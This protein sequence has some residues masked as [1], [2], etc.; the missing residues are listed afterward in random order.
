MTAPNAAATAGAIDPVAVALANAPEDER[1]VTEDEVAARRAA[2]ADP[3]P[4]VPGGQVTAVIAGRA[5]EE[6]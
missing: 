6:G 5:R 2:K 1:P 4:L 3:R